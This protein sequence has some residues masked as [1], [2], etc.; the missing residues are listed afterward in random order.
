[1]IRLREG[2]ARVVLAE[3]AQ[4]GEVFDT[5]VTDPPYHLESIQKRF[6]GKTSKRQKFGQD[7]RFRRATDGFHKQTWDGADP[8]GTKIAQDPEFWALVLDL[9]RPG[10][11]CL[12]FSGSRSGHRQA[13][14]MED[15][16]FVMHPMIPW[17]SA[18][19]FPKAHSVA[20]LAR[21]AGF[22]AE[23]AEWENWYGGTQAL[24]PTCEPIYV[25]QRPLSEG[26]MY[27]NVLK[28]GTGAM[29]IEDC[30]TPNGDEKGRWPANL[31]TDGSD[32]V[33]AMFPTGAD[34][35]FPAFKFHGKAKGAERREYN[36]P[37]VKPVGLVSWLCRLITPPGG[38]V[39]DPFAGSGST[40]AAADDNGFDCTLIER[41]S[42]YAEM[43]RD[44]F[45][46]YDQPSKRLKGLLGLPSKTK[47][48]NRKA[49]L[50]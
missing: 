4:R 44:R 27:R 49:L 19:G 12:A 39:L 45:D 26:T 2:D 15:A 18:Q 5:C 7:G 46:L 40:G 37:T 24:K 21:A 33:R 8:E 38:H 42:G 9:L 16:G 20:R 17:L 23:A 50:S 35:F 3:M 14:A 48:A 10:A 34:E 41:E 43:I 6:S 32:E 13:C 31:A 28:H 47:T 1:M 29:N 11:F 22:E 30:R 25:G 36:H